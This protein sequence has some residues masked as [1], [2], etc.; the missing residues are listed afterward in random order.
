M[1]TRGKVLN[2]NKSGGDGEKGGEQCTSLNRS[3]KVTGNGTFEP[4]RGTKSEH[5]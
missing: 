2:R 3:K 5:W 4:L 1:N